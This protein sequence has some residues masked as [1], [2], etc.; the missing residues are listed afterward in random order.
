MEWKREISRVAY[1]WIKNEQSFL[2]SS[3]HIAYMHKI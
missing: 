1:V 2:K 3:M